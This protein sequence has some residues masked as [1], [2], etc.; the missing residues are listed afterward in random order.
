MCEFF[1]SSVLKIAGN[2]CRKRGQENY[3]AS[4]D[5]VMSLC[6]HCSFQYQIEN[7]EAFKANTIL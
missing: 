7:V 5:K 3:I 4:N 1:G 6:V 2:R